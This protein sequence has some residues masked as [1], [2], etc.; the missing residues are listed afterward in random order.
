[1]NDALK[2]FASWNIYIDDLNFKR[3]FFEELG[4]I[5]KTWTCYKSTDDVS[6]Y[7]KVDSGANIVSVFYK[8][9]CPTN[10]S[11]PLSLMSEQDLFPEWNGG[12]VK[13]EIMA[14][15]SVNRKVVYN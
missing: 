9:K 6:I 14:N 15:L 10:I 3:G 7:T 8:F 12:V 2:D 11:Y 5:P 1:M 4:E 13:M